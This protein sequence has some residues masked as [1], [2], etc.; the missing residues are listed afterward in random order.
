MWKEYGFEIPD[1]YDWVAV[2]EYG[3]VCCYDSKP[4]L[5]EDM[6]YHDSYCFVGSIE[7]DYTDINWEESL[8]QRPSN[9]I[10]GANYSTVITDDLTPSLTFTSELEELAKINV[11]HFSGRVTPTLKDGMV[12]TTKGNTYTQI[13]DQIYQFT[14]SAIVDDNGM[15]SAGMGLTS[16]SAQQVLDKA[17]QISYMEDIIWTK[18]KPRLSMQD[19]LTLEKFADW[20]TNGVVGEYLDEYLEQF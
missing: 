9:Y 13:N 15:P 20:N 4:E 1:G 14:P 12:I 3:E 18:P 17:T 2:D 19:K 5:A 11:E 16:L 8:K 6:W 7:D 10:V